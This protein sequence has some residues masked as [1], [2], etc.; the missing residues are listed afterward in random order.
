MKK[1]VHLADI[2]IVNDPLQHYK[3]RE[4]FEKLYDELKI[5]KPDRIAILGDTL[6]AFID[7]TLES[8]TLCSELLNNLSDLT[9]KIIIVIGNHEIRK[10]NLNRLSSTG[11]VVKMM[12]NPKI[13]LFE[14][15]GFFEDDDLVW[16]NYSH[17]EKNIVPWK[18]IQHTKDNNKT[19]IGLFH[20]PV[21]GCKLPNGM[22]M[23]NKNL[24]KLSD[25]DNND[26][27]L[28]GDIHLQHFFNDT[29]AY[30]GSYLQLTHGELLDNHGFILWT[31]DNKNITHKEYNIPNDY[32]YITF[33]THEGFDYDNIKFNHPLATTKS[34]FKIDWTDVSSNIN[35]ENQQKL[36]K[37]IKDKWNTSVEFEKNRIYT[38]IVNSKQLTE[39]LNINDNQ[40]QQ[41][42]FKEYLKL[43]KFDDDFIE[44]IL[45]IDNIINSK[46]DKTNQINNIEW[47]IDKFWFDNF[48]SY[49]HAE[50]DW[51]NLHGIIQIDGENEHGKTT[52]FDAI[53][54]IILGTTLSTN[55][56]GGGKREANG[57]NTYINNKRDLNYCS[58]GAVIDINGEKFTVLRKTTREVKSKMKVSTTVDYYTGTIVDDKFKLNGELKVNTQKKIDSVIGDFDDF[59]R[60]SLTNSENLNYLLSMDRATFIDSIVRD[61]GYDIFEKKLDIFKEYKKEISKDNISIDLTD[62]KK[63]LED[64]IKLFNEYKEKHTIAKN[65]VGEILSKIKILSDD[66]ET[67]IKKLNKIDNEIS[68]LNI[69]EINEKLE[70]YKN[71]IE[72]NKQQQSINSQ[73]CINL[74]KEYDDEKLNI[75]L[76][77]IKK[78]ENDILDF[79]L[80]ISNHNNNIDKK[81]NNINLILNNIKNLKQ[82]EVLKQE[83]KINNIKNE[84]NNIKAKIDNL[85]KEQI[86]KYN[87][88]INNENNKISLIEKDITIIKEKG[89]EIKKSIKKL[90][91]S[92]E[93]N[94][95][96]TCGKEYDDIAHINS[97]IEKLNSDMNVLFEDAKSKMTIISS[98]KEN[99][100]NYKESIENIDNDE[101]IKK[102]KIDINNTVDKLNIDKTNIEK[103]IENIKNNILDGSPE[104]IENIDQEIKEKIIN[105]NHIKEYEES[106]VE[107]EKTIKVLNLQ[108]DEKQK[109]LRTLEEDKKQFQLY[110]KLINENNQLKL[111]IDTF[112]LNIEQA[113]LHIDKYYDQL[114]YIK[115]NE[116]Y[117]ANITGIVSKIDILNDEKE[118]FEN[119]L[120]G[121]LSES[122]VL[123]TEISTLRENI[124]KYEE[125]VKIEEI[126]KEYMKCI[127]RDGIP[128]FLL[129]KSKDLI[130]M[131]LENILSNVNFSIYFDDDLNLKFYEDVKDNSINLITA[132]GM[133]RTF[134]VMALRMALRSINNKS[135]PNFMLFD[136]IMGKLKGKSIELFNVL[137]DKIK[138]NIDKILII[139][140]NHPINY[141]NVIYVSRDEKYRS[142]LSLS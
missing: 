25:F 95:C 52:I 71:N 117:N 99:I 118:E 4:Q 106:I 136:E 39:S 126:M 101:N 48:K 54:Y 131:E 73:N 82:T 10:R 134:G 31:I 5:I 87:T 92:K 113:K 11:S 9:D 100:K 94:I 61:A 133:Q 140:H 93:T 122:S 108:I 86:S 120:N 46:L 40:I 19:Y 70:T 27:T 56:L 22:T 91:D 90:E 130:N 97:E 21:Y 88:N 111:Q 127:H 26:L 66:K 57:D 124:K 41:D 28:L 53:T 96:P 38:N 110:E 37:Y 50:I 63:S 69:D 33:R 135:R 8:E 17:L 115:E 76:K 104:L 7:T 3:Y 74:K 89:S 49:D 109:E 59:I 75:G 138:N 67:E 103:N 44:E 2:H 62:S 132:S 139:E 78:L 112:K 58:G 128:T 15:S 123:K 72:K 65:K 35:N 60:L 18:D 83:Q 125:Q 1:I 68:N 45:K 77:E 20:D 121:I 107:I 23:E 129:N 16:V 29:I 98:H 116:I 102:L 51:S 119:E 34:K 114:K 43:N 13:V 80:K 85:V 137:L 36:E 105:E 79:K 24:V 47:N 142:T 64:K 84:I 12:N 6:D 81:K 42:I 32:T 141:D 14:K 30:P 55:K